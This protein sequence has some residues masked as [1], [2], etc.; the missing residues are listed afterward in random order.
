MTSALTFFPIIIWK[1]N[2]LLCIFFS[3]WVMRQARLT[4]YHT[5]GL[6]IALRNCLCACKGSE[7]EK[8]RERPWCSGT[9]DCVWVLWA[10][11]VSTWP[12]TTAR[13]EFWAQ[14]PGVA[15]TDIG[16]YH[17]QLTLTLVPPPTPPHPTPGAMAAPLPYD[18]DCKKYARRVK[19][20]RGTVGMGSLLQR[21]RG[22]CV[23]TQNECINYSYTVS[24]THWER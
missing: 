20:E 5:T 22:G 23:S 1:S 9:T 12:V 2:K 4:R 19:L 24:E 21:K 3:S 11:M 14:A 15:F 16:N 13:L 10:E 17:R 7:G 18:D 8:E 6:C